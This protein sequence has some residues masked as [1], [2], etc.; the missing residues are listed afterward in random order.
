MFYARY[1]YRE[2]TRR[3]GRT[4][5]TVLGLA[6]GVGL[7]VAVASLSDGLNQAQNKVLDP[8]AGV[9]TDLMVTRPVTTDQNTGQ[10]QAASPTPVASQNQVASPTPQAQGQMPGMG[11]RNGFG[12]GGGISPEERQQL[13]AENQSVLTDLSK[14]GNPGDRFVH[15]FF[16]PATQLTFPSDEIQ[17]VSQLPG[18][19]AVSGGLTLLAVH[20]E[21]T[22][23]QIVAEIQTGGEIVNIDQAIA[24][25]SPEEEAQI[26]ACLA[27][28][29]ASAPTPNGGNQNG[30][31]RGDMGGRGAFGNCMPDRFRRFQGTFTTPQRIITQALNPPQTDI[32]SDTYTI[33]GV[34]VS[35]PGLGVIT[36][37]Q[38]TQGQFF[39]PAAGESKEAILADAYAQRKALTVGS[40]I[41]LN[42]TIFTVVGLSKPPLGGMAADVYLPLVDLQQ[43]AGRDGR[44]NVLLV[45]ASDA[46]VV[47]SLSQ[48]IQQ[49][50]PGAQVT[51]AQDLA[52]R[53]SGSLV[54][55]SNI[56]DRLGI[57]LGVVA[58]A[59][60]FLIASLL[61]LSSVGRRVREL[62]TL[63][64]LGWGQFV[65][66]RQVIGESLVQGALGGLLGAGLGVAAAFVIPAFVPDLSASA[67]PVAAPSGAFFGLGQ[68][69]SV[70]VTQTIPLEAHIGV[71][72]ALIAMGLALL[73]GL[74]AGTLGAL[75]AAR[76]RPV[77]ALRELG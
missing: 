31:D 21:G 44:I 36:A 47:G 48:A 25:P 65:V 33:A 74:T 40:T 75:R 23:P 76:L 8:L 9:G 77:D 10:G 15:D 61:T 59:A 18:A 60:S 69:A 35:K 28:A 51:N 37:A 12:G 54:D 41:D 46:S 67:A 72:I 24:T 14:L 70:A 50:F 68:T 7:V 4:L 3:I 66:V 20:Q 13:L 1:L 73:G 57:A 22:V 19:A 55:A 62:G 71:T 56:A 64:A 38:V 39:S 29:R 11:N 6:V 42:G 45:R 49:A 30:G 63:K 34:D 58:L 53:V 5:L 52:D 32:T 2:L 16:L 17:S 27:Q 26:Q 43:L